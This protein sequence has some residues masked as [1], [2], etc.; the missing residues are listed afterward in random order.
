ML[1]FI[2]KYKFRIAAIVIVAVILAFAYWYGGGS[3]DS[4]G[5]YQIPPMPIRLPTLIPRKLIPP[6]PMPM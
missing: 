5:W 3:E 1:D 2:K 6:N 4:R